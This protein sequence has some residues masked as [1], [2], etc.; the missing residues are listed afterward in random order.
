MFQAESG[1][2]AEYVFGVGIWKMHILLIRFLNKLK[3]KLNPKMQKPVQTL[4]TY[5]LPARD[6]TWE[7]VHDL[8]HKSDLETLSSSTHIRLL[9]ST[10]PI[11]R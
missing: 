6:E 5:R 3:E 11:C 10:Q 9:Q 4:S 8:H 7:Y 1:S 2:D